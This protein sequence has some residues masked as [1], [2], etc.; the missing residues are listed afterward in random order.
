MLLFAVS[1]RFLSQLHHSAG[2]K[3]SDKTVSETKGGKMKV[4]K[5]QTSLKQRVVVQTEN[6]SKGGEKDK[7]VK[8][9]KQTEV[10]TTPHSAKTVI[11]PRTAKLQWD[12]KGIPHF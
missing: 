8:A 2:S 10:K 9:V 1:Y 7:V 5:K 12:G 6:K 3:S 11:A 4:E